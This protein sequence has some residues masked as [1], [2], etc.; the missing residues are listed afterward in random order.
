MIDPV[1]TPAIATRSAQGG[2]EMGVGITGIA[3][4]ACSLVDVIDLLL[5]ICR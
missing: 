4:D 5:P 2:E 1:H 3:L